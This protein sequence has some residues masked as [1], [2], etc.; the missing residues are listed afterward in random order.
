MAQSL[1]R[2]GQLDE[3]ELKFKKALDILKSDGMEFHPT[4][5]LTMVELAQVYYLQGRKKEAVALRTKLRK[6]VPQVFPRDHPEYKKLM[7]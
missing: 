4:V 6:L 5:V 3:A 1:T 2:L 7:E